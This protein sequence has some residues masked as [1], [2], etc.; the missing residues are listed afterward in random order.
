MVEN[1]MFRK[2]MQNSH[3]Y[4]AL[5]LSCKVPLKCNKLNPFCEYFLAVNN[6]CYGCCRFLSLNVNQGVIRTKSFQNTIAN[7]QVCWIFMFWKTFLWRKIYIWGYKT[8]LNLVLRL[9]AWDEEV[10]CFVHVC[11]GDWYNQNNHRY[12]Q[13]TI[14]E[15]RVIL[16]VYWSHGD[17][18]LFF[19]G[20]GVGG[21]Q[22]WAI[23]KIPAQ[24][25]H[26][27]PH[28]MRYCPRSRTT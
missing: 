2:R 26:A 20:K 9:L 15:V 25:T 14:T 4:T 28:A 18:L 13:E 12:R 16:G 24:P 5:K 1:T 23:S 27:I 21:G 22:G 8:P 6:H 10:S 3:K 11:T 7:G 17:G 19:W